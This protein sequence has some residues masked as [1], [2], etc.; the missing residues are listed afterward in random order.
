MCQGWCVYIVVFFVACAEEIEGTE[1]G[2][3]KRIFRTESLRIRSVAS[4]DC[5]LNEEQKCYAQQ[6]LQIWRE[7]E[8][9]L[10]SVLGLEQG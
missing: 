5:S 7:R 2:K 1:S 4:G 10:M 9:E 3:E 6:V 8:L